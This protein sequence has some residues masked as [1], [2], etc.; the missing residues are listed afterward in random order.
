M[1]AA[2]KVS[3]PTSDDT[4]TI[5]T[6]I[7]LVTVYPVGLIFMWFWTNWKLWVK[8]LVSFPISLAILGILF[9]VLL[10]AVNP[11]KQITKAQCVS[12]CGNSDVS[13]QND[14]VEKVSNGVEFP[15]KL[16]TNFITSCIAN[17]GNLDSCKCVV[18][19]IQEEKTF[20]EYLELEEKMLETGNT[21]SVI[22]DAV[23]ACKD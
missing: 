10:I 4:K 19:Q 2:K 15:E 7:L 8:I 5:I 16:R 11:Y 6:V 13:C 12:L 18:D 22:T 23:N 1:P 9:A 3:T 21:P 17:G 14:C 20:S